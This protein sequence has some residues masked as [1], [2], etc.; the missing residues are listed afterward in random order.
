LSLSPAG[1]EL[2]VNSNLTGSQFIPQVAMDA[3]GDFAVTW[4]DTVNHSTDI[5]SR[6]RVFDAAGRPKGPDFTVSNSSGWLSIK[7]T[8]AMDDDGDFVIAWQGGVHGDDSSYGLYARR[9]NA[10]GDPLGPDFRVSAPGAKVSVGNPRDI[11]LAMDGNG[12]FVV[13]WSEYD[14]ATDNQPTILLARRFNAAGAPMGATFRVDTELTGPHSQ[15]GI[16]AGMDDDGGVLIAWRDVSRTNHK[17]EIYARRYDGSGT[18]EG[19]GFRVNEATE[20]D[21]GEPSVGMAGD[22][23][24]V[25]TWMDWGDAGEPTG[26]IYGRRVDA[27]GARVGSQFQV[28]GITDGSGLVGF[29]ETVAMADNGA[30][31][32]TWL[33]WDLSQPPRRVVMGDGEV[34][35][36]VMGIHY[37]QYTADARKDGRELMLNARNGLDNGF[38]AIAM[39]DSADHAVVVWDRDD[40]DDSESDSDLV[41]R[42]LTDDGAPAPDPDPDPDPTPDPGPTPDPDPGPDPDPDPAVNQAP[43]TQGIADVTVDQDAPATAIPLFGAFADAEDS[44]EALHI[45]LAGNTNAHLFD[46]ISVDAATGLLTL[47]YAAGASGSA[48]LIVRATDSAGAYIDAAFH[49]TVRPGAAPPPAPEPGPGPGTGGEPTTPPAATGTAVLTGRLLQKMGRRKAGAAGVAVFLDADDDGVFD[50]GEATATT[51]ADGSYA[52]TGLAAGKYHVQLADG[53][54]WRVAPRRNQAR[55]AARP[56]LVRPRQRRAGRIKPLVV[57]AVEG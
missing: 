54:G 31:A 32:V 49:V 9:F 10:Q 45:Q 14:P 8:I 7:S 17:P 55:I 12:N 5:R 27:S 20:S 56:V 18:A 21:L 28:S 2:R 16:A 26:G 33:N 35:I 29:P 3:D 47:D 42:R 46:A 19:P 51:A 15:I 38:P 37:Q 24:A 48:V 43:T 23:R 6:A 30:F 40:T 50:A 57:Q 39:D 34:E 36:P 25:V 22:G 52:F 11:G 41:A 13:A 53:S 4:T 1:A 44:D